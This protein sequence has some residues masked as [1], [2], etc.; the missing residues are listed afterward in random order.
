M[1]TPLLFFRFKHSPFHCSGSNRGFLS[2]RG[3]TKNSER[4][5]QEQWR[6]EHWRCQGRKCGRACHDGGKVVFPKLVVKSDDGIVDSPQKCWKKC[7]FNCPGLGIW[8]KICLPLRYMF[9]W[10]KAG[11]KDGKNSSKPRLWTYKVENCLEGSC[12]SGVVSG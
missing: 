2:P 1:Y 9:Q 5:S 12:Q 7:H 11:S 4:N 6:D 8:L 3:D 10:K